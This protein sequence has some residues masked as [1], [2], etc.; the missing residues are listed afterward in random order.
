MITVTV[1]YYWQSRASCFSLYFGLTIKEILKGQHWV[2]FLQTKQ[3]PPLTLF[4]G[5]IWLK[6]LFQPIFYNFQGFYSTLNS[7]LRSMGF[8]FFDLVCLWNSIVTLFNLC[9]KFLLI[10]LQLFKSHTVCECNY[11]WNKVVS[12][13]SFINCY[14]EFW[15]YFLEDC[16]KA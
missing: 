4:S 9:I 6:D 2:N 10:A 3:S 15:F 16:R 12:F 8:W 5:I 11:E 7:K 14:L 1:A 13:K